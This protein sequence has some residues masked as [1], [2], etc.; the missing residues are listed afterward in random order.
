MLSWFR[1][2]NK[3]KVCKSRNFD[4]SLSFLLSV[5]LLW[6]TSRVYCCCGCCIPHF[7]PDISARPGRFLLER[8]FRHILYL[9]L[10]RL[11]PS[12][13]LLYSFVGCFV[14]V[15]REFQH[16]SSFFGLCRLCSGVFSKT[17][18]CCWYFSDGSARPGSARFSP[19]SQHVGKLVHI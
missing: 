9:C 16:F 3:R 17:C 19:F 10:V 4:L 8:D 6:S 18:C 11:L 14:Y 5:L 12:C 2:G 13:V 7:L 15:R 1:S